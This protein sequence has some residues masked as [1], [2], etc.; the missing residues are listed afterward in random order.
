MKQKLRPRQKFVTA[1]GLE[2]SLK[3]QA[4]FVTFNGTPQCDAQLTCNAEESDTRIWLHAITLNCQK[5][6]ILSP[7]TDVYHIGLPIIT[8][9]HL[10][11]IVR[12]SPFS[13]AELRL[14]NMQALNTAFNNDPELAPIP[15]FSIGSVMQALFVCTGCD[16]ISLNT[17]YEYCNF[18][19][20]N[21]DQAPGL[22]CDREEGLLSFFRLVGCAY[23]K[24]HK[25]A[26]IP[27]YLTPMSLFNSLEK[28]G[29]TC[30]VHHFNWL[31]LVRE[32]IWSKIKYEEEMIPSNDALERHWK[33]AC[34]VMTVWRQCTQT[35]IVYPP[36]DGNGWKKTTPNSLAIDWD[37]EENT[38]R[39]R[40]MIAL[41]KTGCGCKTGCQT[42]RCKC[43]RGGNYCFGCKCVR[44]SNLPTIP[45]T[46]TDFNTDDEESDTD[47][48]TEL[49][50]DVDA[51]MLEVFGD[52]DIPEAS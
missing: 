28:D 2:G 19:C 29:I 9:T 7:D 33:R 46:G 11:V 47:S 10:N 32:R 30:F 4:L 37:S 42:S 51:T 21:S 39:V 17:F 49:Q 12:L 26:F 45:N 27:T 5:I 43:K 34:W 23:F 13:S 25:S 52:Y 8:D 36:L 48:E 35:N 16:F 50:R 31:D 40:E 1:G 14:L 44:C 18:I 24:K 38:A 6:Y 3:N 22:L 41:I 20:A 15:P